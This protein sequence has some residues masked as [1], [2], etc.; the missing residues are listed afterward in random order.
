MVRL[1]NE[2]HARLFV[3]KNLEL[4]RSIF[5]TSPKT[6]LGRLLAYKSELSVKCGSTTFQVFSNE[7]RWLI[8]ST[9]TEV[10]FQRSLD[11]A[12]KGLGE[13]YKSTFRLNAGV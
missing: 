7:S 13:F 6:I 11:N 5:F 8:I 9:L 2:Q 10:R 3:Q 12:D 4:S 1:N